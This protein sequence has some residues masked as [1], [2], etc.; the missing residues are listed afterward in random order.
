MDRYRIIDEPATRSWG[1]KYVVNPL[2]I[3]L[4]AVFVPIIWEPPL[5]G[6]IWMPVVW[7][8]VNGYMLGSSTLKKEIAV[9]VLAMALW[10]AVIVVSVALTKSD[11][12]GLT[13]QQVFPYSRIFQFAVFF[14][15]IYIAVFNQMRSFQLFEYTRGGG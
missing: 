12:M 8:A 4:A 2:I 7:L 6:R 15:F 3:L 1:E 5:F 11:S 9:G 10:Y 13:I 14:L